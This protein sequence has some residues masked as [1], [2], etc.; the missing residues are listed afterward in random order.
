MARD[1]IVKFVGVK[2]TVKLMRQ[3]EPQMLKDMRKGIRQIASP[4]VSTIKSSSPKVAPMS[5][6]AG[7][8]RTAYTTPKVTLRITPGQK[9]YGFGSTTS[10][11]VAITATGSGNQYGFDIADMAGRAN[12]P[13]KYR[14]T[15]PFVDPRTGKTVRRRINGQGANMIRVLQ[16]RSGKPASRYVYKSIEDKLPA[17][18]REVGNIIERTMDD[19][20]RRINK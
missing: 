5:G 7:A 6:M 1:E 10:N 18:Q 9:S 19:F 4:A 20:T 3:V 12:N 17:I 8:G 2:E 16:S 13:G 11:L 14:Q 15:R